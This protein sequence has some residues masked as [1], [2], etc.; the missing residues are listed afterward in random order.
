MSF[1][2]VDFLTLADALVRDPNS[3]G[4]EEASLRSAISRAYYAAFHVAR[5]FGRDRGEFIPTGTG[6]DHWLVMNHFRS[7]PDRIRRKI[8]LDLDRL[9]DNR[10][11][12]DY[13]DV[14]AGRPIALAQ[15]SVAVARNV[16]NALNSL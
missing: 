6:Q 1:N 7:S 4:P 16:L 14:L 9:Y 12:A 3:P 15:S 8:G 13:D 2:W 5:N 10:A 11:S